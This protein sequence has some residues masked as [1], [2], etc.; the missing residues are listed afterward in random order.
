MIGQAAD[1]TRFPWNG[2]GI[3][4]DDARIPDNKKKQPIDEPI[5]KEAR[6]PTSL[7]CR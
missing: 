3:N 2:S 5:D 4:L 7:P 6:P 1:G